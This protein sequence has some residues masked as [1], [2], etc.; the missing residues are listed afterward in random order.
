MTKAN[1]RDAI[2]ESMDSRWPLMFHVSYVAGHAI[3][4]TG[5]SRGDRVADSL[6]LQLGR[7]A[8]S[9]P[10]ASYAKVGCGNDY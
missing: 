2:A 9:I 8:N 5:G 1:V 7:W 4:L 10:A 3:T 6:L